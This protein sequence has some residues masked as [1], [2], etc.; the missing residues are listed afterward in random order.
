M[1]VSKR[2]YAPL[3]LPG[4]TGTADRARVLPDSLRTPR[5]QRKG[6]V[7]GML[8]RGMI[9]QTVRHALSSSASSPHSSDKH[10]FDTSVL[11]DSDWTQ[12]P[13]VLVQK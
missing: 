10:S 7:R 6:F 12:T 13:A 4:S 1:A 9:C 11:A 5:Y 8:V 2:K 3:P